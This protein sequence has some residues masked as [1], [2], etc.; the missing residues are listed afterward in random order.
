[1]PSYCLLKDG[2][3]TF[4]RHN[5]SFDTQ[6]HPTAHHPAGDYTKD[7]FVVTETDGT[8]QEGENITGFTSSATANIAARLSFTSPNNDTLIYTSTGS[9]PYTNGN[10]G[11]MIGENQTNIN[12]VI[13]SANYDIGHVFGTNSGGLAG[14]GVVCSNNQICYP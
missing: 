9:D 13:G 12:N 3:I 6:Y 8:F 11:A 1:M 7:F 5:T 4:N 14:L 10:P 2:L